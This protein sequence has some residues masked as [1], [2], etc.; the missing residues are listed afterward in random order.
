[1][2]C[3]CGGVYSIHYGHHWPRVGRAHPDYIAIAAVHRRLEAG[4]H[5]ADSG[6][7]WACGKGAE[8]W[9]GGMPLNPDSQ[10]TIP[11]G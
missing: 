5:V 8:Y 1:M 7:I 6:C 3:L 9:I 2:V 4:A 11:L 10:R